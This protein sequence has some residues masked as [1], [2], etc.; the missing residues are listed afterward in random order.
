MLQRTGVNEPGLL[1]ARVDR[2]HPMAG[3]DGY[4]DRASTEARILT[5]AFEPGDRWFV[6]GDLLRQDEGGDY[7]FVDR[8]ADVV[9]TRGGPVFTR[10]VEDSLY[11]RGDV[12]QVAVYALSQ[13]GDEV[14]AATIVPREGGLDLG[15]LAE[16]V[17]EKLEPH[18]RPR[19]VRLAG[20]IPMTDGYRPQKRALVP[21]A[22]EGEV[23]R[24]GD[25]G[26][27]HRVEAG[28]G[29]SRETG[30]M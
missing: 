3:F 29:A 11:R 5:D 28:N 23:H 21:H 2:G 30:A 24:L 25:D 18:E 4:V 14:V 13:D 27:Y 12:K 15:R 8:L 20:A 1:I 16:L 6:T 9:R 26:R 22:L 10:H 17:S 19:V 7:W